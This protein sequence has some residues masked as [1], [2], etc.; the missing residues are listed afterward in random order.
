[1]LQLDLVAVELPE[2]EVEGQN[3]VADFK[4]MGSAP[5]GHEAHMSD[6]LTA[7]KLAKPRVERSALWVLVKT[8]EPQILWYPTRRTGDQLGEYLAKVGYVA[9]EITNGHFYKRSGMW[10]A[11]CDYLPVCLGDK[12]QAEDTLVTVP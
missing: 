6:Q 9:R 8:K 12:R 1:M 2:A 3:T 10:C 11:W 7:Y 5:D 4:T